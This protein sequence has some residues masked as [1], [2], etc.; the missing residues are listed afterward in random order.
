MAWNWNPFSLFDKDEP[1]SVDDVARKTIDF[2]LY[3][4]LMN[5]DAEKADNDDK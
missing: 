3:S 5:S 4:E 2:L 1:E